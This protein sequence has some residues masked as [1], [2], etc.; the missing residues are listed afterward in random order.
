[1]PRARKPPL[2]LV[3]LDD[4]SDEE[5]ELPPVV[6]GQP[7]VFAQPAPDAVV[8]P[9]PPR[10]P[11]KKQ[12][13]EPKPK[14]DRLIERDGALWQK[15]QKTSGKWT[16]PRV[17]P[18]EE[19]APRQGEAI[20]ALFL[21]A[22]VRHQETRSAEARAFLMQHVV[23]KCDHC[24]DSIKR[25]AV[26][27]TTKTGG[28][29]AYLHKLRATEFR[30]C[31]HCGTTRC[32][33]LDNVVDDAD[34]AELFKEGKV[35]VP[36]HHKLSDYSWWAHPAHGGVEGMRLEKAVCEPC[37]NMCHALQPTSNPR[38]DPKTLPPAV[39]KE[40]VVDNEMYHK[41]RSANITWPRYMY[42]DSLKRAIGQC[43]NLDCP[44]DGPGGGKCIPGVEPA[45]DWEHVNA[46]AKK[47]GISELCN[48][49][50]ANMPEDDWKAAIHAE[51]ERGKCRLL[52]RNCHHLKTHYGAVMR[53]E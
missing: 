39:P 42:N 16:C 47:A 13:K 36:K 46:A 4:S 30:A 23:E 2:Q 15:C 37:C 43:E 51:L 14:V 24:R 6:V 45:F 11:A 17:R 21:Q 8:E 10:R 27:P 18:V 12:K 50:P 20:L 29:R 31:V 53:Y 49:L 44:R 3:A 1:M 48:S 7:I 19:F 35:Y 5:L 25:S 41:R 34:R 26:N 9:V 28:C 32:I 40:S 22:A 52:C 33:E 38:V